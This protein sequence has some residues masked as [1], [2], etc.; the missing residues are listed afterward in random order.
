MAQSFEWT[1]GRPGVDTAMHVL[2]VAEV[3]SHVAEPIRVAVLGLTRK[4]LWSVCSYGTGRTLLAGR[5][6]PSVR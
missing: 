3:G 4:P 1:T 6:G 5:G 2:I